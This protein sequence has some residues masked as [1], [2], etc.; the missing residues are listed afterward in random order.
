MPSSTIHRQRRPTMLSHLVH[1]QPSTASSTADALQRQSSTV[2][3]LELYRCKH[4]VAL[5]IMRGV[6]PYAYIFATPSRSR[7]SFDA[8]SARGQSATW[9]VSQSERFVT[10]GDRLAHVCVQVCNKPWGDP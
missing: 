1:G 6:R 9:G 5:T 2:N 4:M 7:L 3:G 8:S 10:G